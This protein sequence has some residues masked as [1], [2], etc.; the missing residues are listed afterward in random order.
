[1]AQRLTDLVV[2]EASLVDNP[3]NPFAKVLLWKSSAPNVFGEVM[4][5]P[6]VV[7]SAPADVTDYDT[8]HDVGIMRDGDQWY[9]VNATGEHVDGPYGDKVA[10]QAALRRYCGYDGANKSEENGTMNTAWEKLEDL[11][12]AMVRKSGTSMSHAQAVTK[13][14]GTPEGRALYEQGRTAHGKDLSRLQPTAPPRPITK[15]DAVWDQIRA[16]AEEIRKSD[17]LGRKTFAQ[18]VDAVLRAEPRL[19]EEYRQ[20]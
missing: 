9:L 4:V 1:M 17:P 2:T 11:A 19:Y 5:E 15:R 16:K 3:A 6:N 13:I 7:G 10:A 18:A 12:D 20:S 8:V 14:L